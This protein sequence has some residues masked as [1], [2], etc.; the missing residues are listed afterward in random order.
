MSERYVQR[1]WNLEPLDVPLI[2][3][4]PVEEIASAFLTRDQHKMTRGRTA[5]GKA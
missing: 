5:H 1:I 2:D 4:I 3:L